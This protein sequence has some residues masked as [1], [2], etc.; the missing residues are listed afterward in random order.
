MPWIVCVVDDTTDE[1]QWLDEDGP[2]YTCT[3]SN[4]KRYNTKQEAVDD[5]QWYVDCTSAL[6]PIVVKTGMYSIK[7]KK[8]SK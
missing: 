7:A 8:V 6:D 2:S 5:A 4:A 3:E 1:Y